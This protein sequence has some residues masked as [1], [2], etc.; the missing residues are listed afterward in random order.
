MQRRSLLAAAVSARIKYFTSLK[1]TYCSQCRAPLSRFA[2]TCSRC[3]RRRRSAD[4]AWMARFRMAVAAMCMIDIVVIA[5]RESEEESIFYARVL[6]L[7][8]I[9]LIGTYLGRLAS[10]LR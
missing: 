1:L 3:G 7:L 6:G 4:S 2:S 9:V 8:I 10:L 5:G